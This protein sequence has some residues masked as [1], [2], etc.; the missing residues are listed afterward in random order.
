VS[1]LFLQLVALE[2]KIPRCVG[3]SALR[4]DCR[5]R[6]KFTYSAF[7]CDCVVRAMRE[8]LLC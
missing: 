7:D 5:V 2:V 6:S 8:K 4:P 1:L 3:S